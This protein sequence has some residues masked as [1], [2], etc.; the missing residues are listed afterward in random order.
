[1]DFTIALTG[2]GVKG[3]AWCPQQGAMN[4]GISILQLPTWKKILYALMQNNYTD[5][6]RYLKAEDFQK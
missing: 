3:T 6:Q 4:T 5:L 1:M 2:V